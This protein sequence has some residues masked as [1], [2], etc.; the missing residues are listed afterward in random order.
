MPVL[1]NP[2]P[3]VGGYGA[4][5]KVAFAKFLELHFANLFTRGNFLEKRL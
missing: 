5:V 3:Y 2:P 1:K 4:L